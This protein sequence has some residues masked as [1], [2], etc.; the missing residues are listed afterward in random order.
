MIWFGFDWLS[1]G[2]EYSPI[3]ALESY[4]DDDQGKA[5]ARTTVED[6]LARAEYERV[7]IAEVVAV[8]A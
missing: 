5:E 8:V 2:M 4:Q 3:F 6:V 7:K 1:S